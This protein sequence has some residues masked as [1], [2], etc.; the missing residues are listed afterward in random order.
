MINE[1]DM[2]NNKEEIDKIA[3]ES[4]CV[5]KINEIDLNKGKRL[6][7]AQQQYR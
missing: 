2:I 1:S 6:K 4:N 5:I 7:E 3:R